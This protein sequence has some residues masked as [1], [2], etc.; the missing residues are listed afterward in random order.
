MVDFASV[1]LVKRGPKKGLRGD[2]NADVS[3]HVLV[4]RA[5]LVED[6]ANRL[7]PVKGIASDVG[8]HESGH[9]LEE[10]GG[11]L[12]QREIPLFDVCIFWEIHCAPPCCADP[13]QT[14]P[15]LVAQS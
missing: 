3:H 5:R 6:F 13:G 10:R 9:G 11:V 1:S 12:G 8:A 4:R 2:R 15:V 14:G 7:A